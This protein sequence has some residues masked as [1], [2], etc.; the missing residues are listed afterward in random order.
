MGNRLLTLIKMR[1]CSLILFFLVIISVSSCRARSWR[2]WRPW[3]PNDP[4]STSCEGRCWQN[5]NPN[6]KCHC[7]LECQQH[8]NCCDDFEEKCPLTCQDRCGE[9]F[10]GDYKC[11]CNDACSSHNDCCPD[12]GTICNHDPDDEI[13][14]DDLKTIS[15]ELFEMSINK[16]VGMTLDLQGK[17][18]SGSNEDKAPKNLINNVNNDA[19]E[20]GTYEKLGKLMDNYNPDV[21]VEEHFDEE[22][23]QEIQ[24]FINELLNTDE[25]KST[26]NFL[27]SHKLVNDIQDFRDKI[28]KLWFELYDRDGIS[29]SKTL[30][31]SGFEHVF[32][33]ESKRHEVSGFHGWLNFYLEEQNNNLNYFGHIVS[34]DFGHNMYGATIV[35]EWNGDKKPVGGGF[36]GTP[37]E[38][39]LS[40]YT[41]CVMIRSGEKCPM[42]FGNHEFNIKSFNQNGN[43]GSS[44][45]EF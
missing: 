40:L 41:I 6:D 7:N 13:T 32:V 22:Q 1:R 43:V 5:Y 18:P 21:T 25:I 3:R 31:S 45:P 38:L 44:Y 28:E 4:S 2:P 26:F 23:L 39:D 34:V 36:F 19:L 30:G 11:Q 37:P 29:S 15:N 42:K 14:D 12:Y 16:Q 8:N 27:Q 35:Y 33:G 17:V 20:T 24:E 9:P 10:N